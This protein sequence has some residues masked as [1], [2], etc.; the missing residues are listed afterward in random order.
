MSGSGELTWWALAAS[1]LVLLVPVA[2]MAYFRLRLLKPVLVAAVRMGVQLFLVGLFMGYVFDANRLWLTILWV[3]VIIAAADGTLVARCPLR[4]KYLVLPGAL[5]ILVGMAAV[6]VFIVAGVLHEC[7]F[8]D[9]RTTIPLAG[10]ITGNCMKQCVV[11]L[12][13]FYRGISSHRKRYLYALALGATPSEARRPFLRDALEDA[14]SPQIANMATTGLVALPGM[15]TG[16]MIG[17]ASP[18]AAVQ[19]QWL[20]MTGILA[21]TSITLVIALELSARRAFL[22]SGALRDD[23]IAVH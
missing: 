16:V 18:M 3:A 11:G 6:I 5:S 12:R 2:F 14:F 17:G 10:M 4:A 1:P 15:M 20:L 21:A 22:P 13:S 8:L 9:A 23:A 19:Y 7:P